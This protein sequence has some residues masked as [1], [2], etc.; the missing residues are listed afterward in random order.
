MSATRPDTRDR[1]AHA[2]D[3]LEDMR[4]YAQPTPDEVAALKA[5]ALEL[6]EEDLIWRARR[7][8][9]ELAGRRGELAEATRELRR[10]LDYATGHGQARLVARA[11]LSLAWNFRDIG[12]HSA[13]LHHAV[14]AVEQLDDAAPDSVR[15]FHL[16]RLADALDEC[17]APDEAQERYAQAEEVAVRGGDVTRQVSCLN[18]RA[19]GEYLAGHLDQAQATVARLVEICHHH[20]LPLR[21]HTLDTVAR[22]EIS[23]GRYD[24]AVA[25]SLRSTEAYL[26]QGVLEVLA[27]AEFLLTRAAAERL[28]GGHDAA[29]DALDRCREMGD[30]AGLASVLAQVDREQSELYAARGDFE[31]AYRTFR[32]FHDAEKALLSEQLAAQSRLRQAVLGTAEARAQADRF[33]DEAV[34]DPLTGLPNRRYLD[35][36]LPRLLADRRGAAVVAV[37]LVDLDHFK[38]VNDTCS[39]AAGD[40]VLVTV[41]GLLEAAVERWRGDT[42]GDGY[43]ARMGGEE[44]VVVLT[45]GPGADPL[46]VVEH[47]RRSVAG[48][49]WSPVTGAVPVTLSAGLTC[50]VAGDSQFT[51][52]RRADDLLYVAKGAGRDRV[53]HDADAAPSCGPP[54][55]GRDLFPDPMAAA[56]GARPDPAQPGPDAGT[57]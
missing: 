18:N 29:Q 57:P 34:H 40:E 26:R 43:A 37:A 32:A 22:I 36:R 5:V 53:A 15:A 4:D 10:V 52:L 11:H 31:R 21:A 19:Y 20:D 54:D 42:A 47:L 27:P 24:E 30:G 6:G 23:A 39:H 17:G 7:I 56:D 8:A 2:L 14:Q 46:P 33:R 3:L 41:G 49:D 12:D 28:R 51:L 38:R 50:A 48:R 45:A 1:C 13:Y 55:A 9:A 44:F 16:I 35:E 25:T